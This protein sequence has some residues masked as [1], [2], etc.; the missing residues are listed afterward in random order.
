MHSAR[1]THYSLAIIQILVDAGDDVR[2]LV[3]RVVL[4]VA[5]GMVDAGII[6]VVPSALRAAGAGDAHQ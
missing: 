2:L 3:A 4:A 5:I 1:S 6:D